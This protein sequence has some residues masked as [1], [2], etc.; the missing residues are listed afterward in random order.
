MNYEEFEWAKKIF[1]ISIPIPYKKVEKKYK[2]KIRE[3][4]PDV[5]ALPK[6]EAEKKSTD[7]N[8]AF[9]ILREYCLNYRIDFSEQEYFKQHPEERMQRGFLNDPQWGKD[10]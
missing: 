10:A 2:E 7:L 3:A 9:S 6:E 1:G 5:S 4:H 8:K